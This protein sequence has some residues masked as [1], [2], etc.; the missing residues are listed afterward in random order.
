MTFN[1][2]AA[3]D[4]FLQ[5]KTPGTHFHLRESSVLMNGISER[6]DCIRQPIVVERLTHAIF[7]V[8]D[9]REVTLIF[10]L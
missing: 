9:L 10:N 4:L 5:K 8:F 1:Q 2:R 7:E 6:Y 3:A